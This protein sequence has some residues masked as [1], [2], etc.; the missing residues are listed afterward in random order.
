MILDSA[1]EIAEYIYTYIYEKH[2]KNAAIAG[3]F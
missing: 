1:N 3:K 2:M